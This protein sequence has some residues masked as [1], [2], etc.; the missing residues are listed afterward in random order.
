MSTG[1]PK[2]PMGTFTCPGVRKRE[3]EKKGDETE[4]GFQRLNLEIV[5]I[6]ICPFHKD[7][8]PDP[9]GVAH[10]ISDLCAHGRKQLRDHR[11]LSLLQQLHTDLVLSHTH[12]LTHCLGNE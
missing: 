11:L 12:T 9:C 6:C 4:T 7:D 1:S 8:G 5:C 3:M 10:L 2:D